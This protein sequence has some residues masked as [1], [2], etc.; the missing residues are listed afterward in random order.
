MCSVLTLG[1]T[2]GSSVNLPRH[3]ATIGSY[4][5]ILIRPHNTTLPILPL[6]TNKTTQSLFTRKPRTK[7]CSKQTPF[8]LFLGISI[9]RRKQIRLWTNKNS[10]YIQHMTPNIRQMVL[11]INIGYWLLAKYQSQA[12][13]NAGQIQHPGGNEYMLFADWEVCVVKNCDRG[14]ENA[15]WGRKSRAAFSSPRSQFLTIRT[16]PKPANNMFILFFFTSCSKL[17]LQITNGFVYATLSLN[18]LARL[19]WLT[20]SKKSS[21]RASNWDSRRRRDFFELHYISYI[22]FTS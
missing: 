5:S 3:P 7:F 16:D 21:Q 15:A 22:Y 19:L 17:V 6:N 18:R 12:W 11:N 2:G 20:I 10:A 9:T 4:M 14:L 8:F 1:R 13:A